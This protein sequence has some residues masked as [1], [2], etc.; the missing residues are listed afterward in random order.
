M[1]ASTATL[2]YPG[3]INNDLL[4][5]MASLIAVPRCHFLVTSYTPLTLNKHV[6]AVQKTTVLDVMRRLFQTQNVM[7]RHYWVYSHDYSDVSADE[8]W[9]VYLSPERHYG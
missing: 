2:R 7:V 3:P 1:A 5:L 8:G 9:V 4:G 6:S